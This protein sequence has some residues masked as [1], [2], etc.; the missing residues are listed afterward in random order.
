MRQIKQILIPKGQKD[1]RLTVRPTLE[2]MK[3]LNIE[4]YKGI[5]YRYIYFLCK[6]AEKK[7]LI[8][9]CLVSLD[10]ARPK[11]NDLHWTK[12]DVN[13]GKW[14]ECNKPPYKTDYEKPTEYK[15]MTIFDCLE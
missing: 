1:K 6:K 14:I 15:Q 12:K 9:E 13:S 8:K 3:E 5:Q 4:H 11:D 10:Q 2:Q 7:A